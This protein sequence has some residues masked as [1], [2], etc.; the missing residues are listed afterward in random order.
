M[1]TTARKGVIFVGAAYEFR[2]CCLL[3]NSA[4]RLFWG[5]GAVTL[6]RCTFDSLL[7]FAT[8]EYRQIGVVSLCDRR[9]NWCRERELLTG[10]VRS[11]CLF[12]LMVCGRQYFWLLLRWLGGDG[13]GRAILLP[14]LTGTLHMSYSHF[15]ECTS[16][17][18]GIHCRKVF[19][20][21]SE[22]LV[23]RRYFHRRRP[24]APE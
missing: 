16:G 19:G 2:D 3:I 11:A 6:R 22:F 12:K 5:T 7:N 20:R 13:D 1:Q 10:T 24:R 21:H 8:G 14:N 17:S 4:E 9:A 15:V 18:D 23:Y